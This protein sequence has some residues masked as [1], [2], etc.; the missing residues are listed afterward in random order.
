MRLLLIGGN[1]FI[2]SPLANELGAAGHQVAIFHRARREFRGPA[3]AE[4][5]LGDR[6]R[7]QNSLAEIKE[8]RPEV[9]V[10]LILSSGEQARQLLEVARGIGA[11]VVALSSMDVYRA[12]GVLQGV[13]AG[14]L[15]SLPLTEDSPLRTT[16]RLYSPETIER[17]RSTFSWL[18]ENYD[19]IGVEEALLGN[20]EVPGTVLRLP[21]VYGVED[22]LERFLPIVKRISDGRAR[23]ILS[24]DVAAWRGPRGYADNVAHAVA[25][26]AVSDQAAGRIYNVCEEPCLPELEWQRR[27][28]EQANWGGKFVVLPLEHTP[29]H[30]LTP[31]NL[32]QHVVASSERI[33]K[34]LGY[35][36]PVDS[37]EA[38]RRTIAWQRTSQAKFNPQQFD[39]AEEDRALSRVV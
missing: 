7:L 36:E 12:W 32:E 37:G 33:R 26:A 21:M 17:L 1:G 15:A 9:I 4:E 35:R 13:E 20:I 29:K 11:R 16:R 25:L 27:I 23:I 22:P 14:P 19:K 28:A 10:D 38:I 18:D 2:G 31:G 6:N 39:Y 3:E 34:E 30:L 5:I 24:E 8:F